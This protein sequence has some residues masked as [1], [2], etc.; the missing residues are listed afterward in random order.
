M[1]CKEDFGRSVMLAIWGQMKGQDV[2][3]Y[4]GI[5]ESLERWAVEGSQEV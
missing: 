3:T 2:V 4:M 5:D 1:F